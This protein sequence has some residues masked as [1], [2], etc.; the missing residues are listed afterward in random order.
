MTNADSSNRESVICRE[1]LVGFAN[2]ERSTTDDEVE[3]QESNQ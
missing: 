3:E 2:D 1:S